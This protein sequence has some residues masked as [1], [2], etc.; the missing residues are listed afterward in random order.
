MI[1]GLSGKKQSGKDTLAQAL[2]REK[3]AKRYAFADSLKGLCGTIFDIPEYKLWGSEEDKNGPSPLIW[4]DIGL[5]FLK[6]YSPQNKNLD[7]HVSIRELLQIF[8]SDVC[9]EFYKDFW[10]NWTLRKI[11]SDRS[12]AQ[13]HPGHE[14]ISDVRFPNEVEKIWENGGIVIRLLRNSDS[15]DSHKSET[16]LDDWALD[17][18]DLVVDNRELTIEQSIDRF[19]SLLLEKGIF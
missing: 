14:V 13:N 19:T 6:N 1:L 5:S 11:T 3:V 4:R 2:E 10:V 18:F 12:H 16:G 8:G 9:R 15:N 17:K 7:N